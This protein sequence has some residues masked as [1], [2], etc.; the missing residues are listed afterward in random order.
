MFLVNQFANVIE[1]VGG[2]DAWFREAGEFE[3]FVAVRSDEVCAIQF[4]VARRLRVRGQKCAVRSRKSGDV[5]EQRLRDD[6][7]T[8]PFA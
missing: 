1:W 5:V 2:A 4:Q 3:C 7:V 6:C 8:R